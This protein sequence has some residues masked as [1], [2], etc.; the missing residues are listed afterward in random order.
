[1]MSTHLACEQLV[2]ALAKDF[3]HRSVE[4]DQRAAIFDTDSL[5]L[6]CAKRWSTTSVIR[7]IVEERFEN[8]AAMLCINKSTRSIAMLPASIARAA[9][10]GLRSSSISMNNTRQP[11]IWYRVGATVGGVGKFGRVTS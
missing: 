1:M 9:D 10:D 4:R 3:L 6:F 7:S 2:V 5:A 8:R 11:C